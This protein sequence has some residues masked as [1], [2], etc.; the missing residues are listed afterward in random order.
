MQWLGRNCRIRIYR[1]KC[2]RQGIYRRNSNDLSGQFARFFQAGLVSSIIYLPWFQHFLL[3]P[4]DG[5]ICFTMPTVVV[6]HGGRLLYHISEIIVNDFYK[7]FVRQ[8][9]FTFKE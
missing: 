6:S 7:F 8:G 9:R 2:Q 1:C 5:A 3:R 4:D